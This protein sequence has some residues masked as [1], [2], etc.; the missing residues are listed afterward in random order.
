VHET[1]I[2]TA[3]SYHSDFFGVAPSPKG[4][5]FDTVE[6]CG[7]SPHG[8]TISTCSPVVILP[9]VIVCQKIRISGTVAAFVAGTNLNVYQALVLKNVPTE[10]VPPI[11]PRFH[12]VVSLSRCRIFPLLSCDE[13]NIECYK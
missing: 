10:T 3:S 2:N 11:P 5:G 9:F 13:P 6:V 12:L 4:F 8:P 1:R 7:S